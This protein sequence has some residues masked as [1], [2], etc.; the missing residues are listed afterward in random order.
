MNLEESILLQTPQI[1]LSLDFGQNGRVIFEEDPLC[2]SWDWLCSAR[3]VHLSTNG[4][5]DPTLTWM[6][7]LPG[8][9]FDGTDEC[10]VWWLHE[11][12]PRPVWT[13]TAPD[14]LAWTLGLP[15]E[16]ELD[17]LDSHRAWLV[18]DV[19]GFRHFRKKCCSRSLAQPWAWS[20]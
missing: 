9:E 7:S 11:Q 18:Q 17:Y 5:Y 6:W 15:A 2:N 13:C 4:E 1:N 20:S 16:A 3:A 10:G 12:W 8:S 14:E 19:L